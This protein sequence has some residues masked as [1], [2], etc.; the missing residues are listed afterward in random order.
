MEE[1]SPIFLWAALVCTE[2]QEEFWG[3]LGLFGADPHSHIPCA[4]AWGAA[5]A[6]NHGKQEEQW[7]FKADF[8][9]EGDR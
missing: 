4:G 5:T 3:C 6:Q 7:H 8:Q 9:R 1:Y 2:Q